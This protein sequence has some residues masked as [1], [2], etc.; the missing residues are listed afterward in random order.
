MTE[1]DWWILAYVAASLLAGF[2]SAVVVYYRET[3]GGEVKVGPGPM[4]DAVGAFMLMVML[5]PGVVT[6]GGAVLLLIWSI[7]K[8]CLGVDKTVACW[9]KGGHLARA[10]EAEDA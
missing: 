8:A 4:D 5:W 9:E 2:I 10:L 3:R 1:S 7:K 6:I